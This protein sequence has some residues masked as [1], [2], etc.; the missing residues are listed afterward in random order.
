MMSLPWRRWIESVGLLALK[1]NRDSEL[2][3]LEYTRAETNKSM[4]KNGTSKFRTAAG[5]YPLTQWP[6]ILR[7]NTGGVYTR[8]GR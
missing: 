2:Q 4:C 8:L 1:K 3:Y 7:D 5:G 6:V